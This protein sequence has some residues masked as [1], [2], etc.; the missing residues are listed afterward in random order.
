MCGDAAR[1][2]LSRCQARAGDLEK[3]RNPDHPNLASV[4]NNLGAL[5]RDQGRDAEA[6][7]LFKRALAIYQKALDPEHPNVATTLD[8]LAALYRSQGRDA[9]AEPLSKRGLAIREKTISQ[10]PVAVTLRQPPR[11]PHLKDK[12]RQLRALLSHD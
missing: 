10:T 11:R 2:R 8:N 5:Y 12:R 9:E 1:A 4:L 7:P 3:A 6:E